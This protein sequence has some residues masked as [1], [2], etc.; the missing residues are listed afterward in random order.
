MASMLLSAALLVFLYMSGLF[1][2]ARIRKDNSL[3]DIGWGFGFILIAV[4][5]Y[6]RG[7]GFAARPVLVDGLVAVWGIRLALHIFLRNRYRGEDF[8]YARWR[9]EWGRW[10][11]LRSYIQVFLLQGAV[12]LIIAYPVL[13]VNHSPAESLTVLDFAGTAV[14]LFGFVFETVGDAQ[15]AKFKRDPENRG[16]I[17]TTG[18]WRYTRHPN[19]FGEAAMWW[20]I[21]L[22]ALS[23]KG[24]ATA[25]VS[26]MVITFMLVRVSGVTLLEKKYEGRPDFA[27]YARRTNAFLP[28][29]PKKLK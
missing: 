2:V 12:M 27:A 3:A 20:G 21:F 19:Y 6:V 24:G 16:K 13:L 22:I 25:V 29:F 28:W 7:S 17:I 23:V 15:L 10:F 18:L 5:G 4:L 14:W 26:P 9:R 11:V 1:I 8:R